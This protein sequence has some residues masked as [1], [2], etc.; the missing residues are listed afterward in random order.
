[1]KM[2]KVLSPI[3]KKNGTTFW[4]RVGTAYTNKDNSINL[5]LDVLPKDG[6]LQLREFEEGELNMSMRQPPPSI[7]AAEQLP[8]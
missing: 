8:F 4:L 1:M 2:Y 7:E 3:P 5:Y 6:R